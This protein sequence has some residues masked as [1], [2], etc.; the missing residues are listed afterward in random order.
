MAIQYL[1]TVLSSIPP[2]LLIAAFVLLI[3]VYHR[4]ARRCFSKPASSAPT[5]ACSCSALIL[6]LTGWATLCRLLRARNA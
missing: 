4:P 2:I 3:K 5:C 6:G 1:Y